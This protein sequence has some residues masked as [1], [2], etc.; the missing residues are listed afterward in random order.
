MAIPA[1]AAAWF[2][3]FV[4][5]ICLYVAFTDLREMR[6]K[7]HAVLLLVLVFVVV[8]FFVLPP[9]SGGLVPGRIGPLDIKLPIYVWQLTH[10]FVVLFID[11]MGWAAHR[12]IVS[13]Q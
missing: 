2:L 7:N 12:G 10:I 6:I 8:G 11:A 9:W 5:P 1:L 3:P 13:V 4:L